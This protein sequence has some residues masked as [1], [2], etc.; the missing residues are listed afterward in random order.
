MDLV[1]AELLVDERRALER[2]LGIGDDRQRLVLDDH[3]LGGVDDR[4]AILAEHDRDRVADVVD[5]R[6]APAASARGC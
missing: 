2:L 1:G 3:V 5:R 4:V 6:R